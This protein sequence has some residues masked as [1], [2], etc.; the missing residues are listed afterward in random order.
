MSLASLSVELPTTP[1]PLSLSAHQLPD[2]IGGPPGLGKAEAP[3]DALEELAGRLVGH[4]VGLFVAV[5]LV[6]LFARG[7][8]VDADHG[9][10]NGP[11]TGC[12]GIG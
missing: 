3:L 5:G 12:V 8:L 10:A 2:I 7:T 1:P 9:H 6:K 11:G 4:D